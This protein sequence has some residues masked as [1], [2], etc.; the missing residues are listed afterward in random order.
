MV[1]FIREYFKVVRLTVATCRATDTCDV[2]IRL[3]IEQ[4]RRA[5]GR[6][7]R[8]TVSKHLRD[9]SRRHQS[10]AACVVRAGDKCQTHSEWL[11]LLVW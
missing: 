4:G 5:N 7:S 9:H 8:S 11:V 6:V 3:S 2:N 1:L 10:A